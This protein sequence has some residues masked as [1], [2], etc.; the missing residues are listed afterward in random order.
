MEHPYIIASLQVFR[1]LT[2]NLVEK[3]L[4]QNLMLQSLTTFMLI[5]F[6]SF[7]IVLNRNNHIIHNFL[8]PNSLFDLPY[9]EMCLC[10]QIIE[11]M[12]YVNASKL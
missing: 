9:W 8:L 3:L 5:S 1:I 10:I 7:Y 4:F 11:I 12:Q 6:L 2:N